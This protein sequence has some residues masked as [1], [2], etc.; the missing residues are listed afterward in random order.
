MAT[1]ANVARYRAFSEQ[2]NWNPQ[3]RR[4]RRNQ[5]R[6]AVASARATGDE[7]EEPET[8]LSFPLTLPGG[9]TL[10]GMTPF[11]GPPS[12]TEVISAEYGEGAFAKAFEGRTIGAMAYYWDK[13]SAY[14]FFSDFEGLSY[15]A[16]F[17]E[18]ELEL[19]E[20]STEH[21]P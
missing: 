16:D 7:A 21:Q 5:L 15:P 1:D 11:I 4:Y 19:N 14:K 8:K 20:V 13:E 17:R 2:N 12:L 9:L 18:V 6:A 3:A 10:A